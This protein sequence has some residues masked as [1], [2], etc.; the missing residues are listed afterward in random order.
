MDLIFFKKAKDFKGQYLAG[1]DEVGRGPLA[2]PVVACIFKIKISDITEEEFIEFCSNLKQLGVSDSK[3]I[4]DLKREEIISNLRLK[5]NKNQK[6]KKKL[7]GIFECEYFI[8]EIQHDEID[9]INILNATMLAMKTGH[10]KL[11]PKGELG[12][13]LID[14]NRKFQTTRSD[15]IETLVK[16]D[17]KSL[18]IGMASIIAKVYRDQLMKEWSEKYPWYLWDKNAGYGT[19]AHLEAIAQYGISEIHR[20]SFKGVKE[21]C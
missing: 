2:G 20:K 8:T 1:I 11:I 16:G 6:M 17:S 13:V 4:S 14:G 18:L 21:Y 9:K 10:E 7:W 19:A 3:K 12:V 15:L 5:L